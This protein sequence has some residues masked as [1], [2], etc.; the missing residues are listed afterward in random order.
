MLTRKESGAGEV[1]I[2]VLSSYDK[3]A[4]VKPGMG[5]L[6][7]SCVISYG[8]S[9]CTLCDMCIH[10]MLNFDMLCVSS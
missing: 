4:E 2:R 8:L 1:T 10:C 5:F 9:N 3:I 7:V 6:I